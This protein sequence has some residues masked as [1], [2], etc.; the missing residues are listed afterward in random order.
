MDKKIITLKLVDIVARH[1]HQPSLAKIC[2][3]Y[4]GEGQ[5]DLYSYIL[6]IQAVILSDLAC[7]SRKLSLAELDIMESCGNRLFSLG[8]GNIGK[9]TD[10]ARNAKYEFVWY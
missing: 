6:P 7:S 2:R 3:I 5:K 10:E 1:G 8:E 9:V 4:N